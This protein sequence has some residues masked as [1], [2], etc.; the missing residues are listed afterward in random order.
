MLRGILGVSRR[1]HMRSEEI[2]LILNVSPIYEVMRSG[3]LRW[4]GH[5]QRRDANK[6]TRR[7]MNL[8]TRSPQEET[9]YQ[10]IKD[11][12]T[13]VGFTEDVCGPRPERVEE[14]DTA[15]PLKIGKMPSR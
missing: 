3:C 11:E 15:D 7:V 5:F 14:K 1:E 10:Q 9:W 8:A 12:M 6:V 2:R 4:F 13:G